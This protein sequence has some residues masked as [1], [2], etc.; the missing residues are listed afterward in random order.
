MRFAV[1]IIAVLFLVGSALR[2]QN[3]VWINPTNTE[4]GPSLRAIQTIDAHTAYAVGDTTTFA[5]LNDSDCTYSM[6]VTPIAG[7]I[8]DT[9][10]ALSFLNKD[11]GIIVSV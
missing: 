2:A 6:R 5:V 8:N 3:D 1:T 11:L 9:F 4:A 7:M 10:S